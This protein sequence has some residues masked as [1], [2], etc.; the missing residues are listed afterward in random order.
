[1]NRFFGMDEVE[2][3]RFLCLGREEEEFE[4]GPWMR[5]DAV[6]CGEL[7]VEHASVR[8]TS[9]LESLFE[10]CIYYTRKYAPE[11]VDTR[12]FNF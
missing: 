6:P 9:N 8:V 2:D 11:S 4:E 5:D 1:M 3:S 7:I 12:N 10:N